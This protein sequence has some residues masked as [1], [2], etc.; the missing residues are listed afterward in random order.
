M[1]VIV[2]SLAVPE[3][4]ATD[5]ENV[6]GIDVVATGNELL[7]TDVLARFVIAIL[8]GVGLGIVGTSVSFDIVSVEFDIELVSGLVVESEAVDGGI[9]TELSAIACE[10]ELVVPRERSLRDS[11]CPSA[12]T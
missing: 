10:G 6:F 4:G 7:T 1:V 2:K 12:E 11:G 3:I 8:R 9:P 5:K